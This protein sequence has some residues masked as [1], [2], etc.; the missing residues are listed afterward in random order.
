[1]ISGLF[2][3]SHKGDI[4]IQRTYRDDITKAV[5]DA[6]KVNVIHSRSGVKCPINSIAKKTYFHMHKNNLWLVAVTAQ[7][8][9]ATM[10]FEFLRKFI[11]LN[12]AYFG[13][14]NEANVK[15]NFSLIYELLDEVLDNGYPQSTDPDSLKIITEEAGKATSVDDMKAIASQVTGQIGWRREGIKYKKHEVY[16]DVVEKV[17]CLIAPN[18]N[19][20]SSFVAGAI[21]MK[22]HL[23]GMPE[24]KFGINDKLTTSAASAEDGGGGGKKK[25]KGAVD[26]GPIAIDDLTFHQCVKLGKF[27]TN[28]SISFVPPDG[29]FDL[30]K[31]RTTDDVLLPF[32][33]TPLVNETPDKMSLP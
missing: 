22:C 27:D 17:N 13:A 15:N 4:I 1:M 7:N 32:T 14:F 11:D 25:K 16:L 23:S 21:Q 5:V 6:F 18:G 31:Y 24:C 26:K 20:L 30:V 3:F 10:C 33:I 29:E 12:E 8:I 19:V 28:R 9:N 2:I